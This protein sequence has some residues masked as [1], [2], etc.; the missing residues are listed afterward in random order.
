MELVSVTSVNDIGLASVIQ[1]VLEQAGIEAFLSGSGAE[2]VF[3]PGTIDSVH[4]LVREDDLER[5]VELL[6][7]YETSPEPENEE[8]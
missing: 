6:D 4:I 2:D 7:S 3:P 8:E 1:G 5:A